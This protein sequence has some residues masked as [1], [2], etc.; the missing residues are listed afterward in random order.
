MIRVLSVLAVALTAGCSAESSRQGD[1]SVDANPG[2]EASVADATADRSSVDGRP[3]DARA[4]DGPADDGTGYPPGTV[5]FTEDFEDSD[6][7]FRG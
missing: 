2:S 5:L 4:A 6:F 7:G 1:G 3:D